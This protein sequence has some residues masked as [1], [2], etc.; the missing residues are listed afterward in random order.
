MMK[1]M[2][3]SKTIFFYLL[4]ISGIF[5]IIGIIDTM[6]H[7]RRI[8]GHFSE[9]SF[10]LNSKFSADIDSGICKVASIDFKKKKI[11]IWDE[12]G[13][14]SD[15]FEEYADDMIY[16]WKKYVV[17]YS[18]CK[19]TRLRFTKKFC[20]YVNDMYGDCYIKDLSKVVTTYILDLQVKSQRRRDAIFDMKDLQERIKFAIS[21]VVS[22]RKKQAVLTPVVEHNVRM[23]DVFKKD[24]QSAYNN[25]IYKIKEANGVGLM[26]VSSKFVPSRLYHMLY[27]LPVLS[28]FKLSGRISDEEKSNFEQKGCFLLYN[29]FTNKYY[30]GT[31]D[32]PYLT[33]RKIMS[34][35]SVDVDSQ[36]LC[37]DVYERHMFLAK[38]LPLDDSGYTD[39]DVLK[40]ILLDAYAAYE[41]SGYNK[42]LDK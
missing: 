25:V 34:G 21:Y 14:T 9:K 36:F 26:P 40:R 17:E 24:I 8:I 35:K 30:V 2:I 38:V 4:L 23:S 27:Q 29:T 16:K 6:L 3:E 28:Y 13:Y 39:V 37:R 22:K 31:S 1:L 5:A 12:D 32:N 18:N 20:D 33:I 7:Y 11:S 15:E 41:P 10:S 19:C 42:T